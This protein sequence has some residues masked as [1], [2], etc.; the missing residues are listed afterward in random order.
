MS[1]NA[2]FLLHVSSSFAESQWLKIDAC[3][4]WPSE[5]SS[6]Y[7]CD[8]WQCSF[9]GSVA[10]A[11]RPLGALRLSLPSSFLPVSPPFNCSL[12]IICASLKL[13][14]I[15]LVITT[16]AHIDEGSEAESGR[17]RALLLERSTVAGTCSTCLLLS[18]S[19]TRNNGYTC[20]S[21]AICWSINWKERE[22]SGSSVFA[23]NSLRRPACC[24][25][26]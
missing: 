16:S 23:S 11:A 2:P 22:M 4:F 26:F 18:S 21:L 5:F 10:G 25:N 12:T 13:N 15:T 9:L 14:I 19:H 24:C 8:G 6:R 3:N 7:G 20:R 1:A 17:E